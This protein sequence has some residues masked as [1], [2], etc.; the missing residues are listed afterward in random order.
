MSTVTEADYNRASA[1]LNEVNAELDWRWA[2]ADIGEDCSKI[3]ELEVEHQAL[4]ETCIAYETSIN[5]QH[6]W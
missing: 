6:I 1:R 4:V 3:I 2:E 5:L